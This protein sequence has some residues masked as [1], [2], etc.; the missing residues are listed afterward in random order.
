M[1]CGEFIQVPVTGPRLPLTGAAVTAVGSG[2]GAHRPPP[3]H[4]AAHPLL[5]TCTVLPLAH[6]VR[7]SGSVY[8][9]VCLWGTGSSRSVAAALPAA[10]GMRCADVLRRTS[11]YIILILDKC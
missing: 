1:W 3:A 11:L 7:K 8:K 6:F 5:G 10:D 2:R 4:H 9:D